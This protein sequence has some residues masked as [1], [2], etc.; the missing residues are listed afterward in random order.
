MDRDYE[1]YGAHTSSAL[2]CLDTV[3]GDTHPG[4]ISAFDKRVIG[5]VLLA[6]GRA[7]VFALHGIAV[8]IEKRGLAP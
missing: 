1:E 2:R 8:A 5:L 3:N 7:L 4:R 6:V